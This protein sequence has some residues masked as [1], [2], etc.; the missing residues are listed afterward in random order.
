GG[1]RSAFW[2][3]ILAA[4]FD[5]PIATLETQEGSAYGA[6]LLAMAGT[7]HYG[8]VVEACKAAIHEKQR[9]EPDPAA[10]QTYAKGYAVFR[11]IY[12]ALRDTF[13]RIDQAR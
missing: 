9:L 3:Q 12:P 13:Q 4:V 7:G 5:R 1:A 8:S 2:R 10:A 11:Q 6:A